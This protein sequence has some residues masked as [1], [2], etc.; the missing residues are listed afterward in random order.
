MRKLITFVLVFVLMMSF[1][2]CNQNNHGDEQIPDATSN[3]WGITLE[4]KNVSPKGLT[5]V[6]HQTSLEDVFELSTDSFYSL[7]KLE[8]AQWLEVEFIPQ[9]YEVAWT[10]EAWIVQKGG[11]TEW[12][13][14]WNWLYG[15]LSAGEYRI[16]KSIRNF[17]GTGDYDTETFYAEFVIQ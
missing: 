17:R 7:Q 8:D 12:D 6:C 5:L 1:V 4:T 2:G 14:N 3:K 9:E 10:S 15:E 16:V 13:I 11:T